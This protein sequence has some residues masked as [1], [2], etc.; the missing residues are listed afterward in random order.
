MPAHKALLSPAL[1][2]RLRE[3]ADWALAALGAAGIAVFARTPGDRLKPLESR[4]ALRP[5]HAQAIAQQY[6]G[7]LLERALEGV[8]SQVTLPATP[9]GVEPSALGA[10]RSEGVRAVLA[11]PLGNAGD[12]ET[13][14]VVV[15]AWDDPRPH[16]DRTL[17]TRIAAHIALAIA[18][19]RQ[20]KQLEG[21]RWSGDLMQQAIHTIMQKVVDSSDESSH[22]MDTIIANAV[23]LLE[24][25]AGA[26]A[27]TQDGGAT[28]CYAAVHNLPQDLI[29]TCVPAGE[30]LIGRVLATGQPVLLDEEHPLDGADT[31]REVCDTPIWIAVP[32]TAQGQ[33]Q[34]VLSLA[35]DPL[36]RCSARDT[37][38]LLLFARFCGASLRM[39][40][41]LERARQA[42][43]MEQR[44][45]LA[46][47][48][49]D[50]VT[51]TIFS[52]QLAAQVALDNWEAQPAQAREALEM[53]LHLALG[54]S[55]EMRTLLFE[56]RENA[57][58][59]EG[60]ARALERY[61]DMV[62]HRSALPVDLHVEWA[63]R[64]PAPYEEVLYRVAQEA[65]TNV[66]KHARAAHASVALAADTTRASLYVADDGI[67][68]A[69][70][71][72][73]FDSYGLVVMRER[74]SA[75]GGTLRL[76]NRPEGGAYVAVELPLPE[77]TV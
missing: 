18:Y 4:G 71:E 11:V 21:E 53:V 45:A 41:L 36:R 68:F 56:L 33:V 62:R 37:A 76:G 65:L 70:A 7:S 74:V 15:L 22:K 72:P 20:Q 8:Y 39:M 69:T 38:L 35:V 43:A 13:A 75:L 10:L 54:A 17:V 52:L 5:E 58:E 66:L 34:G 6:H 57:L 32:I 55:A 64:L 12:D 26:V 73:A 28:V 30:G 51:Q 25:R 16:V 48:L 40:R 23:A 3:E 14:G 46:R 29:G 27:L 50:S 42:A 1:R 59:S 44:Q 61:V 47:D 63:H 2:S 9:D 60:L 31:L 19:A 49:H 67:G 77:E 24:A